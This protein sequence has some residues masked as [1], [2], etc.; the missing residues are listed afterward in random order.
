MLV[1]ISDAVA[2]FQQELMLLGLAEH[3]LTQRSA[4]RNVRN[5][6]ATADRQDRLALPQRGSEKL[7]VGFVGAAVPVASAV[8]GLPVEPRV[9]VI[10]ASKHQ[11]IEPIDDSI[12]LLVG[13]NPGDDRSD[14]AGSGHRV[15]VF[16]IEGVEIVLGMDPG[17][18]GAAPRRQCNERSLIESV[19]G[20]PQSLPGW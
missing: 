14:P 3:V 19:A 7:G 18:E 9:D 12:C 2:S 4:E 13:A 6:Q 15:R 5:L 8:R 17:I 11:A 1:G 20:H 16:G 10:A